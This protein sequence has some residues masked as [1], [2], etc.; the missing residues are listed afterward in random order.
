M[1]LKKLVMQLGMGT[2][3][4]GESHTKAACR[5]VHNAIRQNVLT[6]ADAFGQPRNAMVIDV[7]I[8][9]QNPKAVDVNEVAAMLPYGRVHVSVEHGGMDT[10]KED[11]G[12]VLLANAAVTVSLDLA[13][14]VIAKVST[15]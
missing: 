1:P 15:V 5:A 14:D 4:Q 12:S 10:P 7:L 8:G 9:V 3:I 2:D 13:A 6:V 11:G